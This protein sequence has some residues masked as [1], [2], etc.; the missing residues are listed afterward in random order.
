LTSLHDLICI[1]CYN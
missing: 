1:L